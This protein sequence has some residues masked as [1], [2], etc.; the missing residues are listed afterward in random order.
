MRATQ[1]R[2]RA[3]QSGCLVAIVCIHLQLVRRLGREFNHVWC[4]HEHHAEVLRRGHG[5][6]PGAGR[7]QIFCRHGGSGNGHGM[8]AGR[9][10]E[11]DGARRVQTVMRGEVLFH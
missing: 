7:P 6:R 2:C 4:R 8:P 1:F 11:F 10:E 9:P 3:D 5:L